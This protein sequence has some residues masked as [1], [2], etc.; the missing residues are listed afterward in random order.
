MIAIGTIIYIW[1][2]R[3]GGDWQSSIIPGPYHFPWLTIVIALLL[4]L[5]PYTRYIANILE[6]PFFRYTAQLSYSL[7]LVH[8]LVIG[9]LYRYVFVHIDTLTVWILFAIVSLL[10]SY[11][12]AYLVYRYI[13]VPWT[14]QK[15]RKT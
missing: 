14:P 6:T 12:C 5:I 11:L 4:I 15:Q 3:A 9:P 1:I 8:M 2:I 7:F 10:L 13:E